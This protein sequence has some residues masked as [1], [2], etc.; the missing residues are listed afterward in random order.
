[1]YS[2]S[3]NAVFIS[4]TLS[5]CCHSTISWSQK[6]LLNYRRSKESSKFKNFELN[7][8]LTTAFPDTQKH[9]SVGAGPPESKHSIE[10]KLKSLIL[11]LYSV[12]VGVFYL[13]SMLLI[14]TMPKIEHRV[15][16][17]RKRARF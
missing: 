15:Q 3:R 17:A 5:I 1:M 4:L 13:Y 12:S 16:R 2:V 7:W 6:S 9:Q 11:K 8:L 14:N 10:Y